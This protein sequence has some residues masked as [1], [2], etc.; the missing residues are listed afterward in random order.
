MVLDW[1]FPSV[2]T[3]TNFKM[4][5]INFYIYSY[6]FQI[7]AR[8][9][10]TITVHEFR[11]TTQQHQWKSAC[12]AA[13]FRHTTLQLPAFA[14]LLWTRTYHNTSQFWLLV[15]CFT[16]S[17]FTLAELARARD[18]RRLWLN[19]DYSSQ[20]F[21]SADEADKTDAIADSKRDA[22]THHKANTA[23]ELRASWELILYMY[24]GRKRIEKL[25]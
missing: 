7:T 15:A 13:R 11:R 24:V 5:E 6:N 19:V 17:R 3:H 23:V 10:V 20:P 22:P 16:D 1:D 25:S 2:Y 18:S 21:A 14:E 8:H 12:C 4:Q 9:C